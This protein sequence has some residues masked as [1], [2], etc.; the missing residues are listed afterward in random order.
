MGIVVSRSGGVLYRAKWGAE[1]HDKVIVEFGATESEALQKLTTSRDEYLM[2]REDKLEEVFEKPLY[3]TQDQL[4]KL[5][6]RANLQ[7]G[8]VKV[9]SHD[10]D[11]NIVIEFFHRGVRKSKQIDEGGKFSDAR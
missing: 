4:I 8:S 11:G 5:L 3:L 9:L 7:G 6:F 1:D 2:S 10:V